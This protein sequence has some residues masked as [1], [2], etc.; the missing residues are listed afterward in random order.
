MTDVKRASPAPS[1][2]GP[3]AATEWLTEESD[4]ARKEGEARAKLASDVSV[5]LERTLKSFRQFGVRHKTSQGFVADATRRVGVFIEAH[6]ELPLSIV[7]TDVLY[8]GESIYSDQELRTSYP[9]LLF[10]DGVQRVV[11]ELGLRDDEV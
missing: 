5:A 1:P 3:T 6:G 9:F 2:A 7:G 8:D 4:A 10:R 11:F